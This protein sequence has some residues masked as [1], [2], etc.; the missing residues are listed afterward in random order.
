MSLETLCTH[1]N[2]LDTSACKHTVSSPVGNISAV[3]GSLASPSRSGGGGLESAKPWGPLNA[4][5]TPDSRGFGGLGPDGQSPFWGFCES[6]FWSWP[7]NFPVS[8]C[9]T[10]SC[11]WYHL[12][13]FNRRRRSLLQTNKIVQSC[14]PGSGHCDPKTSLDRLLFF[15]GNGV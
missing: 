4:S 8:D 14:I 11:E 6:V 12:P 2:I 9:L 10:A 13:S 7:W 15:T 1:H 3:A 5:V